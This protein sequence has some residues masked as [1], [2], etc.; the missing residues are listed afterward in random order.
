MI[1]FYNNCFKIYFKTDIAEHAAPV[2]MEFEREV[3][4]EGSKKDAETEAVSQEPVI[5]ATE[6]APVETKEYEMKFTPEEITPPKI[7][8]RF[9]NERIHQAS[10]KGL[11]QYADPK[12]SRG[13][14]PMR[15]FL[16]TKNFYLFHQFSQLEP[17]N[18][19]FSIFSEHHFNMI[20]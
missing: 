10:F 4:H 3:V 18:Q 16:L 2:T 14:Q 8:R 5:E 17:D 7:E 1:I 13:T 20:P 15:V 6:E 19:K 11:E 9:E 12:S